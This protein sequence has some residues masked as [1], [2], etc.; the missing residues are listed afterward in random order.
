MDY[1]DLIQYKVK[2]SY[3]NEV[4]SKAK[5]TLSYAN[6]GFK[7]V[8]N[9]WFDRL[10]EMIRLDKNDVEINKDYI[11][12]AKYDSDKMIEII[13][14]KIQFTFVTTLFSFGQLNLLKKI[15]YFLFDTIIYM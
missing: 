11:E 13:Y 12:D 2:N 5:R 7:N 6:E 15:E 14:S 9:I 4:I 3:N 8:F 1:I 10:N